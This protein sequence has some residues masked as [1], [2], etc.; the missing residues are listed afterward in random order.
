MV[1]KWL[2]QEETKKRPAPWSR[3]LHHIEEDVNVTAERRW[4]L[5]DLFGH[6]LLQI[7]PERLHQEF[8]TPQTGWQNNEQ[9][10]L[11]HLPA[12]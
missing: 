12:Q 2:E 5:L 3:A 4:L 7:Q 1:E 6:Q 8:C 9:T 10:H 11:F